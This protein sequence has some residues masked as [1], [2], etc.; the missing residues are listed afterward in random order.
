MDALMT[1][2]LQIMLLAVLAAYFALMIT[3]AYGVLWFVYRLLHDHWT[4]LRTWREAR[5][6]LFG[7][8]R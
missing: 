1:V 4:I 8:T 5:A 7:A 3:A 2:L 6:R